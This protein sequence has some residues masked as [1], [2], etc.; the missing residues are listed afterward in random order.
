[1]NKAQRDSFKYKDPLIESLLSRLTEAQRFYQEEYDP[2]WVDV[3]PLINP[4][5]ENKL[6]ELVKRF[7]PTAPGLTPQVKA[8]LEMTMSFAYRLPE[9]LKKK[10][11][12]PLSAETLKLFAR[13]SQDLQT[14]DILFALL[15]LAYSGTVLK[16]DSYYFCTR[17][18][19]AAHLDRGHTGTDF[20]RLADGLFKRF[21]NP[22]EL[23]EHPATWLINTVQFLNENRHKDYPLNKRDSRILL[24]LFFD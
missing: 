8:P 3:V 6:Q 14:E 23:A 9:L 1:M 4:H 5:L 18:L 2:A 16:K 12:L 19:P 20:P 10:F 24:S 13:R 11:E 17:V 15:Y 7:V 22:R 21:F